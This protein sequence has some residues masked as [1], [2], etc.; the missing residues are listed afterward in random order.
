M[1]SISSALSVIAA[2]SAFSPTVYA[3]APAAPTMYEVCR[4]AVTQQAGRLAKQVMY[5]SG[6][7]RRG[8]IDDSA[9]GAAFAAFLREKYGIPR[10]IGMTPECGAASDEASA[11]KVIEVTWRDTTGRYTNVDTG[12]TYAPGASVAPPT[13]PQAAPSSS[14]KT[15][16]YDCDEAGTKV[17]IAVTFYFV[18][19]SP[20]ASRA[21]IT[22]EGKTI[23]MRRD[24]SDASGLSFGSPEGV[25]FTGNSSNN[26]RLF[27]GSKAS[28]CTIRSSP[29]AAAAAATPA[30]AAAPRPAAVTT[31]AVP[32]PPKAPAPAPSTAT[33]AGVYVICRAEGDPIKGRFYNPPVDG[34]DGSYATWQP[35]FQTYMTT[36]Y[37]YQRSVGCGKYPTK[38]AAQADFDSW[39]A[40]AKRSPTINGQPSPV[41]VT[42]WKFK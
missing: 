4:Q 42:D 38:E 2:L 35:S 22:I 15:A 37:R 6:V 7:M 27:R 40:D 24:T 8:Q 3:Q 20:T 33:T 9:Y 36:K 41:I 12:W 11:R 29:S 28:A 19:G 18:E 30:P 39:I 10:N 25:S 26:G 32:A 23:E 13:A 21:A 34:A 16:T 14:S 5:F 31:P 17:T 1:R